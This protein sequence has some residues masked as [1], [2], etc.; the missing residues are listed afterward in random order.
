[1]E[2]ELLNL[3]FKTFPDSEVSNIMKIPPSASGRVYYR[4]LLKDGHTVIGTYGPDRDENKAFVSLSGHFTRSGLPVPRLLAVDESGLYYLQEDLG[5]DCLFDCIA[6]GRESGTFSREE[7]KILESSIRILPHFQFRDFKDI[8]L[9]VC[10]PK[11]RFDRECILWDLNYFKYSF[12][13]TLDI[14]F[15]EDLLEKDFGVLAD[16]ILSLTPEESFMLRDFQSRNILVRDGRPFLIDYQGGR[17]GAHYYDVASFL[18]QARANISPEVREKLIDAYLE[19][20]SA[21]MTTTRG[22][23]TRNL[24]WFVLLRTLQVLGAYGLRGLVQRKPHF[25]MSII[26]AVSNLRDLLSVLDMSRMPVLR[27]A[28]EEVTALSRFKEEDKVQGLTVEIMSFGYKKGV[29][30]DLSGNGGGFVFDCRSLNN[31]GRYSQFKSK[32]GRD[33]EVREF[34]LT[35]SLIQPFLEHVFYLVDQSVENYLERGFSHLQVLFGCTGGQHRSVYSAE[36]LKEHLLEKY[37]LN[38]RLCHREQGI[39]EFHSS[40]KPEP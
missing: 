3:L 15:R 10:Y 6:K 7:I 16:L 30:E 2:Q 17:Q 18:F 14:P 26:P 19:E 27:Q 28:L 21:Y 39:T 8:D 4:F 13:K 24:S 40:L 20:L 38:V 37:A 29:P 23:F 22:E 11:P 1:M 31:P 36:R 34:L 25:L 5:G 9:S 35:Q 33:D 32:T 12:L